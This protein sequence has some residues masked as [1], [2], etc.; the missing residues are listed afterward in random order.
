MLTALGASGCAAEAPGASAADARSGQ[1]L[2][3]GVAPAA[4]AGTTFQPSV[5]LIGGGADSVR[6]VTSDGL[7][8]TLNP[9]A[10]GVGQLALG[11]V[12]FATDRGVGRVVALRNTAA[13]VEVTLGPVGLTDV[14]RDGEFSHDGPVALTNPIALVAEGAFWAD[15]ERQQ[16]ADYDAASG[17]EAAPAAYLRS[18]PGDDALPRPPLPVP[19]L[20]QQAAA[21]V[22]GFSI[23]ARCCDAGVGTD[24]SYDKNGLEANG[25]LRVKLTAPSAKFD[26]KITGGSVA[27]ASFALSGAGGLH[28]E[29]HAAT[30]PGK[31][32]NGYSPPL[33]TSV[34]FK[35]P[36]GT[37]LGVPFFV[38]VTQ[39][40][41]LQLRIP[42]QASFDAEA[43]AT[44]SGGIGFDYAAA[45]GF[46]PSGAAKA[47]AA[48]AIRATNSIAVGISAVMFDYHVKLS[49]GIGAFG[50]DAGVWTE[51]ALQG[52]VAVGAPFGFNIAA[53]AED[54]IEHC[55][56]VQT[57][58][59][60]SYG[61]GY[62]IP[63]PTV[64]L[65]NYFLTAF[66]SQPIQG[67]GG[68]S[69]AKLLDSNYT[70]YP[71]TAVCSSEK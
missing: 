35:V 30:A 46:R 28:A 32:T 52:T 3:Y 50:F 26:L 25:A 70:P 58:V 24:F 59:W 71:N 7:T 68:P 13:G 37:L 54:P 51:L 38:G 57:S 9:A 23:T 67:S 10:R 56:S 18:L 39:F 65:V 29:L 5:V 15:P 4:N 17:V 41:N 8:W 45:T 63:K 42:G 31:S 20:A 49:V 14:I 1:A 34:E 21:T 66:H 53:G 61:V 27:A 48:T 40:A 11:R 16:Q 6:S 62:H 33:S 22:G 44:L 12:L 36:V 64:A 47:D 2:H 55:K 60:T 43:D 19:K 69:S